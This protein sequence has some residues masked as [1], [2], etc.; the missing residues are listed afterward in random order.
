MANKYMKK[1]LNIIREM[2]IKTTMRY[3]QPQTHW[4]GYNKN[5]RIF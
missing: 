4:D 3:L 1:M 5:L 2:Y